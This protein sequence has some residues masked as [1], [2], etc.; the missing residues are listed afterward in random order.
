MKIK[1]TKVFHVKHN[2]FYNSLFSVCFLEIKSNGS[3]INATLCTFILGYYSVFVRVLLSNNSLE[4]LATHIVMLG[5]HHLFEDPAEM[6]WEPAKGK[7]EDK[8]EDCFGYLPPLEQQAD[9]VPP[10]ER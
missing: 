9:F 5:V 1:A 4:Q 7:D 10:L 3:H 8:A 2:A 6:Q